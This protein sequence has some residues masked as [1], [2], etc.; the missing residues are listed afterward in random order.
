MN[1]LIV[2]SGAREHMLTAIC[3]RSQT[4]NT[5]FCC[6]SSINP[7][8]NKLTYGYAKIDIN[9][10]NAVV[11]QALQWKINLAIIGPEAPL[12]KGLA[13]AFEQH[14]IL[15]V[16]PKKKFAQLETSKAFTR[17]LLKKYHI[18]GSPK[19][20]HFQDLA[21]VLPFLHALGEDH[22]VVKADGLMGGKG[23]KVAGCHL[24]SIQEAFE[25]CEQLHRNGLSFVIEEKLIG[26]EFSLLNFC[27]GER[28]IP[29]PLVQ[30]H[31]R[32]FV[33]DTGPNT[34]GMGS[35]SDA[36]HQLPF[37]TSADIESAEQI[38]QSVMKALKE[39][40]GEAYRGILYGSFMVTREGVYLIEYNTRFGDPEAL[41]IL[42]ILDCDFVQ[43]CLSL[44]SGSLLKEQVRFKKLA[45]V[46][47]YAVPLG[48]PD[49]PMN[50]TP[51]SISQVNNQDQLYFAAV[52]ESKG[53]L[54]TMG[55]RAIA[56]VGIAPTIALAEKIAEDEICRIEGA[57]F[58]REDIGKADLIDTRIQMMHRLRK[59][60]LA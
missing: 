52:E 47:K 16:G 29:M 2:G 11:E 46:C 1:I 49:G 39:E 8:I 26:Q 36:N 41:N 25:F 6:G 10:V 56:V 14:G 5:L 40:Y 48:Y 35:Y 38:N 44:A 30:D 17:D 42:S 33:G 60:D 58:H 28:L 27:D 15:T 57:L 31:K 12:E 21:G 32:A 23:V 43:L 3:A 37:L 7:G 20:R 13:D 9:D 24:H 34:G 51:F 59:G 53:V 18:K 22:Y 55:S 54:Q 50:T 45:T 4:I 19:Y